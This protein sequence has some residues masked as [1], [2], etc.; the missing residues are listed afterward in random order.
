MKP[1]V[2][3][4]T[5]STALLNRRHLHNDANGGKGDNWLQQTYP[6]LTESSAAAGA[7]LTAQDVL[8]FEEV[9]VYSTAAADSGAEGDEA[10]AG[11]SPLQR[12]Q[13]GE[14]S[15]PWLAHNLSA[16]DGAATG[17]LAIVSYGNGVMSALQAKAEIDASPTGAP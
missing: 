16:G 14:T 3:G 7:P 15:E 12:L 6:A 10:A 9:I 11:G 17:G 4:H 2:S 5:D 13:I 1:L 8:S